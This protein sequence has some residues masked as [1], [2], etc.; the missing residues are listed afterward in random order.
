MLSLAY[1]A[2]VIAALILP[3]WPQFAAGE[4]V[5]NSLTGPMTIAI[6]FVL[7]VSVLA[8]IVPMGLAIRRLRTFEL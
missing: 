3:L 8:V 7:M 2:T 6:G 5:V 4:V 1:I